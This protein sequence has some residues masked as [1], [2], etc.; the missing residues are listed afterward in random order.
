M[1]TRQWAMVALAVALGTGAC[2]GQQ[3]PT[4]GKPAPPAVLRVANNNFADVTIYVV[5]SGMR[6]RLGTVSGLSEQQFKLSRTFAAYATDLYLLA[7][8]VGGSR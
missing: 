2:G 8:P 3:K 4:V 7:D 1:Q 5:Q 6:V